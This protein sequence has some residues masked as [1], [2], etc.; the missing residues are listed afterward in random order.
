MSKSPSGS[1][2]HAIY[3]LSRGEKPLFCGNR[4]RKVQKDTDLK[5]GKHN[6][7]WCGNEYVY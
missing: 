3:S 4:K 7:L 1:A 6:Q 5:K 2:L